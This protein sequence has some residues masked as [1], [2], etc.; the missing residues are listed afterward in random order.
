MPRATRS[1][2]AAAFAT[3]VVAVD[4]AIAPSSLSAQSPLP[5]DGRGQKQ[6]KQQT[7]DETPE[8]IAAGGK[9]DGDADT[10]PTKNQA[11]C[12]SKDV[13]EKGESDADTPPIKNMLN[14]HESN[15]TTQKKGGGMTAI[16]SESS[17]VSAAKV[18]TTGGETIVNETEGLQLVE[19]NATK[20]VSLVD[21]TRKRDSSSRPPSTRSRARSLSS[22]AMSSLSGGH[23]SVQSSGMESVRDGNDIIDNE[24]EMS[25]ADGKSPTP[26]RTRSFSS[27]GPLRKRH[28]TENGSSRLLF[29][30]NDSSDVNDQLP[31]LDSSTSARKRSNTIDSFRAAMDYQVNN[32]DNDLPAETIVL[33]QLHG[34]IELHPVTNL[35]SRTDTIDFLSAVLM[36]P[37]ESFACS[38]ALMPESPRGERESKYNTRGGGVSNSNGKTPKITNRSL[39]STICQPPKESTTSLG[40]LRK[41]H[42]SRSKPSVLPSQGGLL[43]HEALDYTKANNA[44]PDGVERNV[45]ANEDECSDN[46]DLTEPGG[47]GIRRRSNTFDSLNDDSFSGQRR[48]RERSDTLDFLTAAIA[49][50]MGHDLDAATA[51]AADDGASFT[52]H[53]VSAPSGASSRY[54]ESSRMM[55]SLSLSSTMRPR[56]DTLDSTASSINSAKLDFFVNVASEQEFLSSPIYGGGGDEG[57]EFGQKP[58]GSLASDYSSDRLPHRRPRSNTL[59]IYSNMALAKTRCDTIDFLVGES[60][61]DRVGNID[62]VIDDNGGSDGN[63]IDYLNSLC[64]DPKVGES[65]TARQRSLKRYSSSNV[66]EEENSATAKTRR[67]NSEA[68]CKTSSSQD[69]FNYL[70]RNRLES[71]GGMSDLS[72]KGIEALAATHSALKDSG[73]MDDVLAAAADLGFDDISDGANSLERMKRSSLNG[74]LTQFGRPRLDSL[75]SMSSASLPPNYMSALSGPK[76]PAER[77]TKSHSTKPSDT[78]SMSTPSIIVDY[79]AIA[80][81]VYAANAATAGLDWA[82]KTSMPATSK[83]TQK[84]SK[85][86]VSFKSDQITSTPNHKATV[87]KPPS[88]AKNASRLNTPSATLQPPGTTKSKSPFPVSS[89]KI[90]FVPIPESTKTKEEMDAIRERARAAAGYVPPGGGPRPIEAPSLT[91]A[92][93]PDQI[94]STPYTH[95]AQTPS[96]VYSSKCITAQSQQKWED[97]FEC[98]VRYIEETRE[99]ATRHMNEDQ[100]AAWI[101]DGNVPTSYKTPCGKAL[102]RWINN[103]RSAKAKDTLRD[104]REVRLVSTGLK[105]SVITT[106]SWKYMLTEL[107]L[108][109][110]EQTKTGRPW[111]SNSH[112]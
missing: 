36:S 39:S 45:F 94:V 17:L 109:I 84:K 99:M 46:D 95:V 88:H 23:S 12:I 93:R 48:Q 37:R 2:A 31:M 66:K 6:G 35:R 47:T 79:D 11:I 10:P 61:D 98:L 85:G 55:S 34:L 50:G 63:V 28:K 86:V 104:D 33:P 96:S 76:R 42:Q 71:W 105:W 51:A 59:E 53:R 7:A 82:S 107:E 112:I 102:G 5:A 81:A 77:K 56:S 26:R 15:G 108:Y 25:G 49:G 40:P 30:T 90:P 24:H 69:S 1:S 89:I 87:A 44:R 101:W 80:S 54:Y 9:N 52:M 8:K 22:A 13:D 97:M 100:K 74:P 106:N 38:G 20:P 65:K 21:S 4:S 67:K 29:R 110:S 57:R 92:L 68:T 70:D 73:V 78:A 62:G 43:S 103:Q 18:A 19:E 58:T 14:V 111:V 16:T 64:N 72:S 32:T 41:R 60:D 3:V 27:R 83:S 75:A 91:S